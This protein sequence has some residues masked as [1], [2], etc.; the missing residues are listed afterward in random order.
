MT[1]NL[2]D[3]ISQETSS[4]SRDLT[5]ELT[6]RDARRHAGVTRRSA[7]MGV[8]TAAVG[9]SLAAC[10]DGGSATDAPAV[11][12]KIPT[13]KVGVGS[14][15]VDTKNS[16]VVTQPSKG[17]FK[18]FSSVC[19]HRGCQV[20]PPQGGIITCACHGSQFDASTGEVKAGPA[21]QGLGAR[22]VKVEGDQL[23]ITG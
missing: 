18:A 13:S 15:Y 1:E 4:L 21:Q 16:V 19:T 5:G 3:A 2:K 7:L 12:V 6:G 23:H 17:Q 10:G 22:T 8:S 9:V 11:D 20:S 14:G